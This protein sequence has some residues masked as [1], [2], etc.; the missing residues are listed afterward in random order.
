VGR[1]H[2]E[3]IIIITEPVSLHPVKASP[4]VVVIVLV[5]A[6]A[7]VVFHRLRGRLFTLVVLVRLRILNRRSI[8]GNTMDSQ[9]I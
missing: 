5:G 7:I 3:V 6:Y 2:T 4:V 1:E 8:R 9:S